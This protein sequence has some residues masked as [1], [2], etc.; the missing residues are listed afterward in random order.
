MTFIIETNFCKKCISCPK[1]H[2]HHQHHHHHHEHHHG[3]PHIR[4]SL[5]IKFGL[6]Q[7]TLIFSSKFAL[8]GYCRSETEK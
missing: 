5:D 3:I 1:H 8:K 2:R 4:N 6:K 7:R